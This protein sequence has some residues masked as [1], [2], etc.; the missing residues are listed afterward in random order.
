MWKINVSNVSGSLGINHATTPN[1]DDGGGRTQFSWYQPRK[2]K[3][4]SVFIP[5]QFQ[6]YL[7]FIPKIAQYFK[8]LKFQISQISTFKDIYQT[9]R[10]L[11]IGSIQRSI[12]QRIRQIFSS[13]YRSE[14]EFSEQQRSKSSYIL[15]ILPTHA[16]TKFLSAVKYFNIKIFL[17][18]NNDIF[19]KKLQNYMKIIINHRRLEMFYSFYR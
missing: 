2:L 18:D 4:T 9:K 11:E 12:L 7:S 16:T 13:V 14:V 3:N 15:K 10:V 5:P 19:R 1:L 17:P 6:T 8:Y